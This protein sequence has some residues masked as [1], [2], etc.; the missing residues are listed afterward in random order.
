[1]MQTLQ[2]VKIY[3]CDFCKFNNADLELVKDHQEKK[4]HLY[5]CEGAN[6]TQDCDA[7]FFV[8][9]KLQRHCAKYSHLNAYPI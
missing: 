9:N 4:N 7:Y 5:F 6:G 8:L 1:M 3:N 2:A